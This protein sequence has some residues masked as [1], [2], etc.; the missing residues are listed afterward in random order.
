MLAE[1]EETKQSLAEERQKTEQLSQELG[2]MEQREKD[3]Q[4]RIEEGGKTPP[5]VVIASPEDGG[6]VEV[7]VIGLRG[8]VEDDRGITRIEIFVNGRPLREGSERGLEVTGG[9]GGRRH[10][11]LEQVPLEEGENRIRVRAV[12]ADGLAAEKTVTLQCVRQ[13]K[14]IWAV[15]VGINDYPNV[16]PL[17]FAVDDA[18]AF[19]SH[20]VDHLGIPEENVTLLL[21][22]EADLTTLRSVLGTRLKNRAGEDDMV[23]LYFAGHGA[24]ERDVMSPDGDGLEKYLLPHG[25]DLKDLYA[26]ALPMR[27]IRHVFNRIRSERLVFVVDSCY[28]GASGGRTVSVAGLRANISD[29]FLERIASGKGRVILSASGA[30]E[31]S[32]EDEALGHGVF[33]YYLLEGLGG[34]ADT[35]GDGLITVDEAYGYVSRRVPDATGQE[36]HPVKKGAVEGR[37]V[38]GVRPR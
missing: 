23:I 12:D 10:A 19:H 28:S 15:V 13:R 18:R 16:R 30:N 21:D 20:L 11:F 25:A 7:N 27:E 1:F 33:T 5:V 2:E 31:V 29:G 6:T 26:S 3:L 9:A 36:Q 35:D 14:K 38:I 8:V 22:E 24:T 34:P 4:V 37:L 17:R 32:E